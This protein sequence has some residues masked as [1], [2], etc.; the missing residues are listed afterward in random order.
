[1]VQSHF[2]QN[3][4]HRNVPL[5][6]CFLEADLLVVQDLRVDTGVCYHLILNK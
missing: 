1:M 5:Y 2:K 3:Y 4:H 6:E